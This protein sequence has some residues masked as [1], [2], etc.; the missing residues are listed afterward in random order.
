MLRI[1]KGFDIHRFAEN[2]PLRIGGVDIPF[3]KGCL[4]HSDGDVLIH[5]VIDSLLGATGCGD[6]G[7]HFPDS[8]PS[9]S[10]ASGRDLMCRALGIVPACVCINLDMTVF[11]EQPKLS[12]FRKAIEE[13]VADMLSIDP[14]IVNFKAKT[15]ELL[16][17]IGNGN[18][19]AAEAV[20]LLCLNAKGNP[21]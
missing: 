16:G 18:A 17:E 15:M 14:G 8:N 13:S 10:N 11:C 3:D 21:A 7:T 4:A 20:M 19:I 12:P 5:A 6:I 9:Y 2:I 1:G